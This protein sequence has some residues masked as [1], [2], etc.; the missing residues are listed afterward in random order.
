MR[1][2]RRV[3]SSLRDP[4]ADPLD[5]YVKGIRVARALELKAGGATVADAAAAVGFVEQAHMTTVFRQRMGFTPG[6]YRRQVTGGGKGQPPV[7]AA[8]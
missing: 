6:Q 3:A 2:L 8:V 1:L 4:R 7:P 5:Q